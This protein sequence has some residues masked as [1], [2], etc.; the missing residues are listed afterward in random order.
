[1]Y[2]A[3]FPVFGSVL[4]EFPGFG[5]VLAVFPG[6]GCIPGCIPRFWLYFRVWP[7]EALMVA[8]RG[9]DGGQAEA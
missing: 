8:R 6:F 7:G 3:V 9:P 2:L 1:M 4:A 5:S